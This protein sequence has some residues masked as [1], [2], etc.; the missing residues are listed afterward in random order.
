M[1]EQKPQFRNYDYYL[2]ENEIYGSVISPGYEA[3]SHI[4]VGQAWQQEVGDKTHLVDCEFLDDAYL[5]AYKPVV[6]Y[7]ENP[8]EVAYGLLIFKQVWNCTTSKSMKNPPLSPINF[9]KIVSIMRGV[10][11]VNTIFYFDGI[12]V[13]LDTTA[14]QSRRGK[15]PI[16]TASFLEIKYIDPK[17][18]K[19]LRYGE[20]EF[21]SLDQI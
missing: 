18:K 13:F 11:P 16:W 10:R 20:F 1:V 9:Y 21:S 5:D 4:R 15:A 6:Y 19:V 2:K 12:D 14:A 8:P 7:Y 17:T 3:G